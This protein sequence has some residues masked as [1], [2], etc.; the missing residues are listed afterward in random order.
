MA[1]IVEKHI[2]YGASFNP[3]HMGHFSAITQML[4][5]YDKVIVFPYPKKHVNG[6]VEVLP[7][8]GQRMKMLDIFFMEFFPQVSSRLI[9]TDLSSELKLKDRRNEGVLHTY[10]YLQYVKNHI[11]ENAHLSVCLGFEAQH[12]LRKENFYKE[13][14]IAKEFGIFYLQEENK[15][16]SEELR[17]FFSNHRN[18]KS[19]K[20][21][22]YIR[23]AVGNA[24][25]EH[26]FKNNLYGIKPKKD[27]VVA[28]SSP[29]PR[30]KMF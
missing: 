26:I 5:E 21:E 29:S 8:M 1:L 25:T 17:K 24:L 11:P 30:R 14:E 20:D 22:Q 23:Y 3:P 9:L 2:L 15:I 12:A 16:K 27:K 19:A 13:E 18:L 4:E 10:D 28:P 7:P 6:V